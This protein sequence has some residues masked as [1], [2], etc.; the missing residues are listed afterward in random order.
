MRTPLS[1]KGTIALFAFSALPAYAAD[2]PARVARGNEVAATPEGRG[3]D[4]S[5]APAIQ[6]AIVACI[7]PGTSP[8][9]GSGKFT[10]VGN[11]DVK[12]Q[13]HAVEVRPSTPV[14]RCFADKFASTM[15]PSPPDVDHQG[16][17]YPV[18][19]EMNITE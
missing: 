15:L 1:M 13:L 6:T 17:N 11:V 3:Y 10:L 16:G 19:V 18:T 8:A 7:P 4:A 5:L 9:S 2:F 14:S 12:G